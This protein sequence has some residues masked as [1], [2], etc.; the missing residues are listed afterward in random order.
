MQVQVKKSFYQSFGGINFMDADINAIGFSGIVA[1]NIGSRSILAE[2]SYADLLK[3]ILYSKT[4]G[5]DVLDDIN[6]L[7]EKLQDHPQLKISSPDTIEYAF[8]ELRKPSKT[9]L[10]KTGKEHLVNEHKGFNQLSIKLCKKAGLLNSTKAHTMDY[11]GHI[12]ENTKTDNAFTY[13][14]SEE[15]YPVICSINKLPI[16]LQNF[17]WQ[18][19]GKL[20]SANY[21]CCCI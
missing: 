20:W 14:K 17:K 21:H 13:K 3:Q 9:I 10:T 1:E 18:H 7:K 2:Y 15:Y 12:I 16:Y 8:Q 6:T 19:P 11:D 4:I 5:G